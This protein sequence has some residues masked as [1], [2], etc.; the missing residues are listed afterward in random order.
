MNHT[1]IFLAVSVF[2]ATIGVRFCLAEEATPYKLDTIVVTATRTDARLKEAPANITVITKEDMEEKSALTLSDVFQSEPGVITTNLL[3]NPKLSTIDIRGYGETAAQNSLFLVDGRRVNDI[4]MSGPDLMQIPVEMIERVEVYRGPATVLYGDNAIGGVIN[5]ILKKGEGK[6]TV[7]AGINTGSYDLYNPYASAFGREGKLSYYFLTSAYDTTGYRHNNDLHARDVAG[8]FSFH[9]MKNLGLNLG[10]G[11]HKDT[12]GLPGYLSLNDFAAGFS[13]KDTKTPDDFSATEDNFIDM[14]TKMKFGEDISLSLGGFYRNRHTSFHYETLFGLWGSMRQVETFS[15]TPK[16]TVTKPLFSLKNALVG[17]IDYYYVPTRSN[18]SG[19]GTSST[20]KINKTED[21]FYLNDEMYLFKNL[22]A[23]AGYRVTKAKYEFNSSDHTGF[24]SPIDDH[25]WKE[26]EAY[27]MGINY[28][29]SKD[30]NA[31]L[32]YAKGFRLPTTDEYFN[33][34]NAPPINESLEPHEVKEI[35]LGVR[36]NFLKNM[37][38]N[39][40][41]FSGRHKNEIYFNPLTFASE[42][43]DKTKREGL[44]TSFFW[45]LTESLKLDVGYSYT[46]ARFDGGRFDGNDLPLVPTHKFSGKLC[47]GWKD[48]TFAFTSTYVGERYMASDM[49]NRFQPLPGTTIHDLSIL[50]KYKAIKAIAAVKNL[51]NKEY[52]AYGVV[53]NASSLRAFYPSAGRQFLLGLEY[54]FQNTIVEE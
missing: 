54:T 48:L 51:T 33:V 10:A 24:L 22:L 26:K 12:C 16:I 50:Y 7:K 2:S 39:A 31:F 41:Y 15:L 5:I 4:S 45:L 1:I 32:S 25:V 35:D 40:T 17:G 37:G 38:G 23:S 27:R 44:E 53:D 49:L 3:N 13:R 42:N 52:S 43:Y 28:L 34:F 29:F 19:T 36:W 46:K 18:D 30:G 11:H 47:Y 6:P 14:D 8:R 9:F 20:T 21:G